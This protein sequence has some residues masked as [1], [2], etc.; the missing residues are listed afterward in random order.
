MKFGGLS[1]M[2]YQSKLAKEIEEFSK[3]WASYDRPGYPFEVDMWEHI[4]IKLK[5]KYEIK[6]K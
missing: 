2:R 4:V 5:E 1:K 3:D 6:E